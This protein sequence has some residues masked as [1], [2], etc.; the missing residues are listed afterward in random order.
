MSQAVVHGETV[1]LAGQCGK[2][3]ASID[4]QTQ[5]ALAKISQ[6]LNTVGSDKTRLLTVTIWLSSIADY[7]AVNRIW[8]A[9]IPPGTAPAR[10]CGEVQIAGDGYDIEI[11]CTAALP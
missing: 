7:D 9:W 11:I 2:P 8:D 3:F 1:Y 10:S 4:E 5:G 6:H